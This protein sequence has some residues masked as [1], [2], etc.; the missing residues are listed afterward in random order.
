MS[1]RDYVTSFDKLADR[2]EK[3]DR[4]RNARRLKKGEARLQA[5]EDA[6]AARK[7]LEAIAAKGF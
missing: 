1:R 5:W 2:V 7:M 4:A 6:T 3:Q